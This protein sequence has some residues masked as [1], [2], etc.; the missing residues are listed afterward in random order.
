MVQQGVRGDPGTPSG[1]ERGQKVGGWLELKGSAVIWVGVMV[2]EVGLH[3]NACMFIFLGGS[4]QTP[5]THPHPHPHTDKRDLPQRGRF[6]VTCHAARLDCNRW[7]HAQ[8]HSRVLA[9]L[10]GP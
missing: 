5:T 7:I 1:S 2:M 9:R 8:T 6:R 4:G 10:A 3:A